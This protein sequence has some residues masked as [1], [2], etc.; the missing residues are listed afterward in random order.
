MATAAQILANQSNAQ[1]STGPRTEEGKAKSSRNRLSF[2]FASSTRF[3][4]GEDP[5]QFYSL[6]SDF[7]NEHQPATP[8]EQVLV[9]KMAHHHWITLRANRLQYVEVENLQAGNEAVNLPL[10]LRYQTA[11]E[12]A[13]FRALTALQ[14]LKKQ[15]PNPE[16]GFESKSSDIAAEYAA[17]A[18]EA[19]AWEAEEEQ[20]PVEYDPPKRSNSTLNANS[21]TFKRDLDLLM[22][23]TP[24]EILYVTE[25][26]KK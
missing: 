3:I 13:F 9:E 19:K 24:S 25:N 6:L 26:W 16:I 1:Q 22:S 14:K 10:L 18:A 23:L 20:N 8:T 2:G 15:R 11:S 7:M 21:P 4:A 17:A 5:K 12:R